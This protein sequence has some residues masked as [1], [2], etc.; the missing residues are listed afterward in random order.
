M[1]LTGKQLIGGNFSATGPTTF[2]A[3]NPATGKQLECAFHE[4]TSEDV[5]GAAKLSEEC[6]D[7]YRNTPPQ[8]RSDFLVS[9]ANEI[10]ALGDDLIQRARAE[11]G[12][13]EARLVGE[14]S[15]I[16]I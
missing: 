4:G 12:L 10:M 3:K 15:L 16:H 13:P 6:F 8:K 2:F 14:L 11:T 1:S 5:D 7:A 9:I